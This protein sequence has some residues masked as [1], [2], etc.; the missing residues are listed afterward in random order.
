MIKQF[1]Q[2]FFVILRH[3]F[4]IPYRDTQATGDAATSVFWITKFNSVHLCP[5]YGKFGEELGAFVKLSSVV[6]SRKMVLMN[7]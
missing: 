3:L 4:F 5:F 2:D 7:L 1:V 6:Q